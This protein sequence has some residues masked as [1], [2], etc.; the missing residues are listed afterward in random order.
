MADWMAETSPRLKA[1]IAGAL[2]LIT[3]ALGLFAEI[4]V[5]EALTVSGDAAATAHNI[6]AS[7]LVWRLGFAADLGTFAFST[8]M[9]FLF[10]ELFKPVSRSL[11]SIAI[12]FVLVSIATG[13]LNTLNRL[14]PLLLLGSAHSPV[15]FDASQLQALAL[16]F[17][18]LHD[19]GFNI[20]LA[21]FG[22]YCVLIGCV[23]F[24]STFLPQ[25]LGALYAIAGLCYVTNSF[26]W[27]LS[28]EFASHLFPYMMVPAFVGEASLCLWL[29][30]IGVNVPK[31]EAKSSALRVSAA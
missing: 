8:A 22:V 7:E 21:F 5:N 27:F 29:L 25:I 1:R 17:L 11:V 24:R 15:G 19:Q 16:V 31:W 26:A 3:I 4:F 12:A 9:A 20:S 14:A 23:I 13:A 28:P 18:R 30:M 10:Y 2:Y 6:L